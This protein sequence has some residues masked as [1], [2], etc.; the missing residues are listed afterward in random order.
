MGK[1]ESSV[2]LSS[3]FALAVRI[4]TLRNSPLVLLFHSSTPVF[5]YTLLR[6]WGTLVSPSS[7][8]PLLILEIKRP[9]G[10]HGFY[11][12]VVHL[13]ST[14]SSRCTRDLK[15]GNLGDLSPEGSVAVSSMLYICITE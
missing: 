3:C 15:M 4:Q 11:L 8:L 12:P 1:G 5:D 14:A 10:N 7:S 13:F 2:Q 6:Y 9:A